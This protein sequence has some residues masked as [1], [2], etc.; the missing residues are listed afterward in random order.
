M[1]VRLSVSTLFPSFCPPVYGSVGRSVCLSVGRSVGRSIGWC[2]RLS[3]HGGSISVCGVLCPSVG[4]WSV[5]RVFHSISGWLTFKSNQCPFDLNSIQFNSIQFSLQF[6]SNQL[7]VY[8]QGDD[9]FKGM[10]SLF[11]LKL[12]V[13]PLFC[14]P[15]K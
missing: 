12:F 2:V 14:C 13:P 3:A 4:R 9:L 7:S 10:S 5:G 6:D 15:F 11:P 1:S 8:S